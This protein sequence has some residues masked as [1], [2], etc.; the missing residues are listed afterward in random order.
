MKMIP[1]GKYKDILDILPILCVDIIARNPKGEYLL[2]KRANEPKKGR[3]WVIGGRVLKGETLAQAVIRKAKQETGIKIKKMRP[4]GYFELVKGVNPLGR[5]SKYH[6][7]SVVFAIDI[8]DKQPII[9][10]NQSTEY[11]YAKKL[12]SDFPVISF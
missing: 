8:N 7:I 2:I 10:D 9:L 4:V 6:T 5:E 1:I 12:P 11:K 3:W